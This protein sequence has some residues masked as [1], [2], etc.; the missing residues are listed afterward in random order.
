[1]KLDGTYDFGISTPSNFW[2]VLG[3]GILA[4]YDENK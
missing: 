1:M 2:I 3:I 4:E